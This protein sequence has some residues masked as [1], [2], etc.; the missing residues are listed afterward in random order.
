MLRVLF[1]NYYL[2]GYFL[3]FIYYGNLVNTWSQRWLTI[4]ADDGDQA[5]LLICLLQ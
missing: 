4:P 5:S 2:F 3:F 1:H